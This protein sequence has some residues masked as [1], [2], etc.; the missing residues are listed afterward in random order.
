MPACRRAS[1]TFTQS[2]TSPRTTSPLHGRR[3]RI[4]HWDVARAHG[5]H[6]AGQIL[7]G[8]TT[9]FGVLPYFFGTM[10]DWAY[11]EYV[12][13]GGGRAHLRGSAEDDDMSAAFLDDDDALTG[14][15]TV[16]RPD[17][18][19]A[20]RDLVRE[21]ARVRPDAIADARRPAARVPARRSGGEGVTPTIEL[22]DPAAA[23][24]HS[25]LLPQE[26]HEVTAPP[27]EIAR[28]AS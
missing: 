11:L 13:L 17:D 18:L 1:S 2:A 28:A 26:W 16:G 25:G 7:A 20:A 12:G 14:L 24:K 27:P 10:G 6:V 21:R 23:R 4:E 22:A 19:A 9:P 15:I 3:V 5:A 8:G